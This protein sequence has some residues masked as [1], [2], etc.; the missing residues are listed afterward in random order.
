MSFPVVLILAV[1]GL[2]F[3]A[4]AFFMFRAMFGILRRHLRKTGQYWIGPVAV[5]SVY[6]QYLK[7]PAFRREKMTILVLTLA[8]FAV[9]FLFIAVQP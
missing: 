5:F 2:V 4:W 3:A 9:T 8:L 6:G 1:Q 7:D